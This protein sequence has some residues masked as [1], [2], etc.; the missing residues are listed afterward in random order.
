[1]AGAEERGQI[2]LIQRRLPDK[3][4]PIVVLTWTSSAG[5]LSRVTVALITSTIRGVPSEVL[6]DESDGMKK[7]CVV[8][9]HNVITV[10]KASL[11]RH[12]ASL[13]PS[14]MRAVCQALAFALGCK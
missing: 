9:L 5:G 6:L 14:R 4:S 13:S 7:P 11:G 8:N 3:A 10:A 1:M 2:R 12:V